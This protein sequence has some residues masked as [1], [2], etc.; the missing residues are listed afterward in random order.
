M[1]PNPL[2]PCGRPSCFMTSLTAVSKLANRVLVAASRASMPSRADLISAAM[3]ASETSCSC[4]G[5]G[6]AKRSV[7]SKGCSLKQQTDAVSLTGEGARQQ[8][9]EAPA[10]NPRLVI[11]AF[12]FDFSAR[13]RPR[14]LHL[15][16]LASLP[17]KHPRKR[18]AHLRLAHVAHA[19]AHRGQESVEVHRQA[20][21]RR[22]DVG[23]HDLVLA[24][25]GEFHRRISR[26]HNRQ[27]RKLP[28]RYQR[29]NLAPAPPPNT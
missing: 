21:A 20:T 7:K 2:P 1:S 8:A 17:T 5:A 11:S 19:R 14:P 12:F 15:S 13:R 6:M 26:R 24:S 27:Q 10:K 4:T 23:P 29:R 3:L 9:R 16:R 25:R 28:A 22:Q 18:T